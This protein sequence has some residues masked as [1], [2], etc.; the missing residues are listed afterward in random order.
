MRRGFLHRACKFVL[1]IYLVASLS[2][3]YA[4]LLESADQDP[5]FGAQAEEKILVHGIF[6]LNHVGSEL[7]ASVHSDT[8]RSRQT[9]GAEADDEDLLLIKRKR[10]VNRERFAIAPLMTTEELPAGPDAFSHPFFA[11]YSIAHDPI[12]CH[13]DGYTSLTTGLSPPAFSA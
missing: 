2:P 7:L 12:H 9:I 11:E 10:V 4:S 13:A 5:A 6:W 3:K 8:A 1:L